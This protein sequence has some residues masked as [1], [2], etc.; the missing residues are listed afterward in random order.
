[1]TLVRDAAFESGTPQQLFTI[2]RGG[3]VNLVDSTADGERFAMPASDTEPSAP[4]G[5][6][7]IVNRPTLLQR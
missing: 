6:S 4:A 5:I 2:A 7:V 1:M 3:L